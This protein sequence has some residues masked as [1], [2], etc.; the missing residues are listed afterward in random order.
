MSVLTRITY[1]LTSLIT[2]ERLCLVL[3]PTSSLL[4]NQHRVIVQIIFVILCLFT[5]HIHELIFYIIIVDYSDLSRNVT[6]CVTNYTQSSILTYNRINVFIH[7]FIPFLIQIIS[8]TILF[9]QIACNRARISGST[10]WNILIRQIRT[11]KEQYITPI[12]IILSSL[13]QTILSFSY[14]CTELKQSW[15][16]YT[17]LTTYFLSYLPQLLG[18]ILYVLPS[19][20]YLEEF[21]QTPIGKRIVRQSQAAL[22]RQRNI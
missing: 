7:Y 11:Q 12:I 15:Q 17:L 1:W 4:K 22:T 5:M 9:I 14:T 2:I 20:T 18:F 6:L 21:R 3:F 8:I 13:P 19:T 16:R 10:F